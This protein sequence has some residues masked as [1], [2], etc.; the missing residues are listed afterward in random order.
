MAGEP[1]TSTGSDAVSE[2][3][4]SNGQGKLE[5]I[6]D[7]DNYNVRRR[8]K[9]LHDAKERCRETKTNVVRL[10]TTRRTFTERKRDRLVAE[11][12]V[13][14]INELLPVLKKNEQKEEFLDE[15]VDLG[16]S[17]EVSVG[18]FVETRGTDEDQNK[19]Y[20][21]RISM[22]IWAICNDAFEDI[23][24]AEFQ[25]ESPD[26]GANPIDPAGRFRGK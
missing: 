3:T 13:D 4:T 18:E 11:D 14:Y 2:A 22:K 6:A 20:S 23:A 9:Q 5:R 17:G 25:K 19:P 15:S 7:P 16:R 26:P 1:D 8:L 10:E 24:G 12:V 21:Y